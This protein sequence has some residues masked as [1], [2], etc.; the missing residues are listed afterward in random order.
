MSHPSGNYNKDTFKVLKELNIKIGFRHNALKKEY[1][2]YELPRINHV[3]LL[4]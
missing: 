1:N 4:D 3:S 2:E